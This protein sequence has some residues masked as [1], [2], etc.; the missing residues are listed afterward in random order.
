MVSKGTEQQTKISPEYVEKI[1][2]VTYPG[3]VAPTLKAR[4]NYLLCEILDEK[5]GRSLAGNVC[6]HPI[7]S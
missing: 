5:L 2:K 3:F 1:D 7:A 4:V 6:K